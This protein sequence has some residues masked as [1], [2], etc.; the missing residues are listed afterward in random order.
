[1]FSLIVFQN[2]I[3]CVPDT[4][5]ISEIVYK[6][7]NKWADLRNL[8][9]MSGC[10]ICAHSIGVSKGSAFFSYS[11]LS[12]TSVNFLTH[13]TDDLSI[14][15]KVTFCS[16]SNCIPRSRDFAETNSLVTENYKQDEE[17]LVSLVARS[18]HYLFLHVWFGPLWSSC[19]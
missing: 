5:F 9:P 12:F 11:Q 3:N 8:P 1:M 6:E 17:G 15:C 16:V 4:K 19:C 10:R 14:K 2:T 7:K 18:P 13:K